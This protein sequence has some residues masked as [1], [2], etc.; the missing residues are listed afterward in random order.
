MET[1][2][3]SFRIP[4]SALTEALAKCFG[5]N[6]I[7]FWYDDGGKCRSEFD[8]TEIDG[9]EKLVIAGN[10]FGIKYKV[11][12]EKPEGKFLIYSPKSQP[13]PADDWLYDLYLSG[14]SFSTDPKSMVVSEMGFPDDEGVR[15]AITE[16]MLPFFKSEQRKRDVKKLLSTLDRRPTV[17]DIELALICT[18]CRVREHLKIEHVLHVLLKEL[19]EDKTDRIDELAKFDLEPALWKRLGIDYGYRNAT[20]PSIVDFANKLFHDA[21]YP[22]VRDERYQLSHAALSFF[23][24]WKNGV[25]T[26]ET[27]KALSKAV[28][29]KMNV[30]QDI[31]AVQIR[32]FG[33]LDVFR[34]I[35]AQIVKNLVAEADRGSMRADDA[36]RLI[37]QR[38]DSCY[39]LDF[40]NAY[41]A[42]EAAIRFFAA[43]STIDLTSADAGDAIAKYAGSWYQIDQQYRLFIEFYNEAKKAD[44]CVIDLFE[45]LK[46]KVNGQYVHS[47][48]D[49]Q[50][51]TFQGYVN[52]MTEWKFDGVKMQRDFWKDWIANAGVNVCVIIS[53]G[54]RYEIGKELADAIEAT[55]RYSAEITPMVSMLPSYTQLGM[56]ALLPH[57]TLDICGGPDDLMNGWVFADGKST[58]G[59]MTRK[60]ILEAL[61]GPKG[62]AIKYKDVMSMTKA[63]CRQWQSSANVLYVYHNIIDERGD[64]QAS[65]DETPS[66]AREAISEIAK[67]IAKVGGDYRINKFIVTSDHGFQY[68][69][70]V[71]DASQY[72]EDEDCIKQA[73]MS[74]NRFVIGRN[75]P[76]STILSNFK[77]EQLGLA[78]GADIRIAKGITRMHRQG[79]GVKFVH[80]GASLQEIVVPVVEIQHV[81]STREDVVPVDA[82]ILV[83]GS[84]RITTNRFSVSVYQTSPVG[85]DFSRRV[86]RLSLRSTHGELLSDE[87]Q[88]VLDSE[89][90]T[91]QDRT[92]SAMLTLNHAANVMGSGSVV[93]KMESGRERGGGLV[94]FDIYKE[95]PMTLRLAV[96]NFFD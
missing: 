2:N 13:A 38:K 37:S 88:M 93:L 25:K 23:N 54:L 72:V 51:V 65:E 8:E 12:A 1:D 69:D 28:A 79:S 71:L 82:E 3:S 30:A 84:G 70:C 47:Y 6:R 20:N 18:V 34:D 61:P 57:K 64:K 95:K 86:V 27:F 11:L 48:L 76:E 44:D 32:D 75:L 17:E 90:V 96:A 14:V 85:E 92:K 89:A 39:W 33:S 7:V 43:L 60:A 41:Q 50:S 26:R 16:K 31:A 49:K 56:A 46:S 80:G 87:V 36:A 52:G 9:V 66:A 77:S 53:D 62:T 78:P 15:L 68:Q 29:A 40:A 10:E 21:F 42:C 58:Q 94:D 24:D 67:L 19:A 5:Q 74:N 91:V 73:S 63:Q 55:H 35:D 22:A 83:D 81:R 45:S 4:H 59:L